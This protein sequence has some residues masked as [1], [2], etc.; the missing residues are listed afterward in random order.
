MAA[1]TVI[2]SMERIPSNC[3]P[4]GKEGKK[5]IAKKGFSVQTPHARKSQTGEWPCGFLARRK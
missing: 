5:T 1:K 3:S 2:G 4:Q